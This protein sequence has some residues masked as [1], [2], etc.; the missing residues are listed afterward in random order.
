MD[1]PE[2]IGGCLNSSQESF[3]AFGCRNMHRSNSAFSVNLF[4]LTCLCDKPLPYRVPGQL[5]IGLHMHFF[6][7]PASV[8]ADRRNAQIHGIG[9]LTN[10]LA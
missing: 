3:D 8:G 4:T 5:R 6:K 1:T 10:G 7:N 9:D 2:P